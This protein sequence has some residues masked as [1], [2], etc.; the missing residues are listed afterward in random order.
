MNEGDV[1]KPDHRTIDTQKVTFKVWENRRNLKAAKELID[2]L[3]EFSV[4]KR[5]FK[6]IEFYLPQLAHLVIHLH[7]DDPYQPLENFTFL[8]C[9]T[10]IHMAL[11]LAFIFV[12]AMED[13]QPEKP[14]GKV[15]PDAD[16]MLFH[17]CSRLLQNVERAVVYGSFAV[18][19]DEE[20][21]LNE[22][23]STDKANDD[24]NLNIVETKRFETASRLSRLQSINIDGALNGELYYKRVHRK[25]MFVSKGWKLRYFVIDQHVLFCYKD[26]HSPFAMRAMSLHNCVVKAI[27]HAKYGNTYFEVINEAANMKYLIRGTNQEQCMRWVAAI[28]KEIEIAPPTILLNSQP[29]S[30]PKRS[31]NLTEAQYRRFHF[32][33]QQRAFVNQLTTI[34]EELRFKERE[35][36]KEFLQHKLDMLTPPPFSYLP[37]CTSLDKFR[38]IIR[39]LPQEAH[40]FSTKARCPALML[41]EL[42]QHPNNLDYATFLDSELEN[43]PDEQVISPDSSLM[44]QALVVDELNATE[45]DKILKDDTK[46]SSEPKQ[47]VYTQPYTGK[48]VWQPEGYGMN[49][50]KKSLPSGTNTSDIKGSGTS[51]TGD[52]ER[53]IS[54]LLE[55][56]DIQVSISSEKDET[57]NHIIGESF[58][59]KTSRIKQS[60]PYGHLPGWKLGGLI[61]KSNDDVRQEV[62][63]MQLLTYYQNAFREANLP[64][65]MHTY[66]ILSTSKTTGL[67]EL[68]PNAISLDGLKKSPEYPGSLRKYFEVTYGYQEGQS[69]PPAFREAINAYVSSMAAYSI[70]TYLLGI[71][72]RHNG[73][74][75]I[76]RAGHIIHIDFGFVFGLAPG[77]AFSME[78]APWK[79]TEEMVDVMGGRTSPD[80]ELY[81]KLCLDALLV[82]RKHEKQV[83]TLM[84]IMTFKS[85]YPAF[86]YNPHSIRDF[87]AKLFLDL[88]DKS[89]EAQVAKLL[90]KSYN[91]TGTGLY[92]QFQL[93]TNK[94]AV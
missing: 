28:N 26:M 18:T 37:L 15:N 64:I 74:V 91:H 54:T 43:Y 79:L 33:K 36:R 65:W 49:R 4:E 8:I 55:T 40:A 81:S 31:E 50:I 48:T 82:A 20:R 51:T 13:F 63:V 94:I 61:A 34:C 71:K 24:A 10:S 56:E 57:P 29:A 7:D 19:E 16:P 68:I 30:S 59:G 12:A 62:F 89:V 38:S 5:V 87:R 85:N 25:S 2:M 52:Q 86:K 93:A 6:D 42:E 3:S 70:V 11:E 83:S 73:N 84:E 75:M 1:F 35:F 39:V 67:I 60:S 92:D 23:V 66:R 21:I 17:K 45:D 47:T 80:Y 44:H 53:P 58:E 27:D 9:Q 78:K 41:F 46:E 72:D 90:Q 14:D 77:K 32:F 76:D 22:L 69:E 88:P